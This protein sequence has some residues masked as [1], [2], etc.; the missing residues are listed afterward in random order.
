MALAEN[1]Y[2]M[3]TYEHARRS[4]MQAV[5]DRRA[6]RIDEATFTLVKHRLQTRI[7]QIKKQELLGSA[8]RLKT[9]AC[10]EPRP[11]RAPPP[12]RRPQRFGRRSG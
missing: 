10:D 8:A 12:S 6:L 2:P 7:N 1:Q 3:D 11:G 9:R 4:M 5:E